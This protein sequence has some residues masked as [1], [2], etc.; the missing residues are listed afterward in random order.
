MI[1][2]TIMCGK[3]RLAVK[4]YAYRLILCLLLR[5]RAPDKPANAIASVRAYLAHLK[6]RLHTSERVFALFA[7]HKLFLALAASAKEM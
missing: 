3:G 5:A 4:F 6:A 7:A 1:Q 2:R